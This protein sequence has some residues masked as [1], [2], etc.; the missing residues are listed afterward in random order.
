LH[1]LALSCTH[2]R[3]SQEG[4]YALLEME[5]DHAVL[6]DP[7]HA[8]AV[9][10]FRDSAFTS[11]PAYLAA[12]PPD[13]Q[14][15]APLPLH[16][17]APLCLVAFMWRSFVNESTPTSSSLSL[18]LSLQGLYAEAD[19]DAHAAMERSR[20]ALRERAGAAVVSYAPH[21]HS[22]SAALP[23]GSSGSASQDQG[24]PM[25][26]L[27]S[28]STEEGALPIEHRV[29]L[30]GL[31]TFG[32]QVFERL[33]RAIRQRFSSSRATHVAKRYGVELQQQEPARP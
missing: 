9:L 21:F 17:H 3:A 7:G 28:W 8:E 32:L 11:D 23:A 13:V 31:E 18:S 1:Y 20:R 29:E 6:N 33:W 16:L 2:C 14:V 24:A 27:P 5:L 22:Y 12:V 26:R 19:P 10:C 15:A 4:G 25:R 30:G